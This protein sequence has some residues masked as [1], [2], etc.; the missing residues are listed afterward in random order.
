MANLELFLDIAFY[1]EK[2]ADS[3][4][5][6]GIRNLRFGNVVTDIVADDQVCTVV[7]NEDYTLII[8]GKEYPI[9]VGENKFVVEG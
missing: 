2:P 7:A 8:K 1:W 5:Q 3:K 9:K 6:I 4:G